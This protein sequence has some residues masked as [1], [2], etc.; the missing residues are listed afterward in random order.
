MVVAYSLS[1]ADFVFE[2]MAILP[3]WVLQTRRLLKQV[4]VVALSLPLCV[5]NVALYGTIASLALA[6]PMYSPAFAG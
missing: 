4:A 5:P 2:A 6:C 3:A 1:C